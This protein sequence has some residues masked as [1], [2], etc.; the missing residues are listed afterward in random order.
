[1]EA[2]WF[3]K[4]TQ[5]LSQKSNH[6]QCLILRVLLESGRTFTMKGIRIWQFRAAITMVHMEMVFVVIKTFCLE[7][8]LLFTRDFYKIH[9][10]CWQLRT[11]THLEIKTLQSEVLLICSTYFQYKVRMSPV[12][13]IKMVSAIQ[14]EQATCHCSCCNHHSFHMTQLQTQIIQRP[15]DQNKRV[16]QLRL[17]LQKRIT[18]QVPMQRQVVHL[19]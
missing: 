3:L 18:K 4:M 19:M 7:I 17:C 13:S 1:M 15:V 5:T 2:S 14:S 12:I 10:R 16:K 9:A 11:V 8:K 6:S